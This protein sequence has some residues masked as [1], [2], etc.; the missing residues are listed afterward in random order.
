[1]GDGVGRYVNGDE[2]FVG[3][4]PAMMSRCVRLRPILSVEKRR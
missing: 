1:M 2:V 3:S 4:V